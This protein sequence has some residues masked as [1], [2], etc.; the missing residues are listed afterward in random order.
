MAEEYAAVYSRL[1]KAFRR[2]GAASETARRDKF[3]AESLVTCDDAP[4]P[5]KREIAAVAAAPRD[6]GLGVLQ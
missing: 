3:K 6:A 1:A 5:A 4:I 2:T